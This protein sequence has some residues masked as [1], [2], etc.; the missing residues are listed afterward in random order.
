MDMTLRPGDFP[1]GSLE[2]RMAIRAE[3]ERSEDSKPFL[4]VFL[5]WHPPYDCK[6]KV[7]L[8]AEGEPV[9]CHVADDGLKASDDGR[10][11]FDVR[12]KF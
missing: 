4:R 3:L 6:G 7:C 1:L 8:I 11:F 10:T 5:P 2:S 9:V 12:M